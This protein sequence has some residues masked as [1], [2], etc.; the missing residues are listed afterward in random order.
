[1]GALGVGR[2]EHGGLWEHHFGVRD[3]FLLVSSGVGWSE[4]VQCCVGCGEHRSILSQNY[5]GMELT[6]AHKDTE[7]NSKGGGHGALLAP[8]FENTLIK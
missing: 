1:M 5:R 6:I 7:S 8:C 4:G 3:G 2:A